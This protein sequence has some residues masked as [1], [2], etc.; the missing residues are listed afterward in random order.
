MLFFKPR[1][2]K[3]ESLNYFKPLFQTYKNKIYRVS[4]GILHNEADSK[5]VVQDT[6][7]TA[8]EKFDELRDKEKFEK[9][10]TVIACNYAKTKYT[11]KKRELLVEDNDKIIPLI[12]TNQIFNLPHEQFIKNEINQKIMEHISSLNNHYREVIHLYYYADLSYEEISN[13]LGENIG[14]VKS[15]LYRAKQ[16][17]RDKLLKDKTV[18][19]ISIES[20][21]CKNEKSRSL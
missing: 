12:D 15:R 8:F 2:K 19:T 20:E 18:D 21:V 14:T 10:I 1:N 3:D 11:K 6:F 7:I 5:D 9:W 4:Y 16:S 13:V 17:L